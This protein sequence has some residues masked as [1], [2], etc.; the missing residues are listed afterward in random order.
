M[1]NELDLDA[2]QIGM[3]LRAARTAARLTQAAAARAI[4]VDT[5]TISRWE[6]GRPGIRMDNLLRAAAVYGV[7]P[8]SL[9]PG[10]GDIHVPRGTPRAVQEPA[11][12]YG[13]VAP[14]PDDW[15]IRVHRLALE[16]AEAGATE[17][18]IAAVRRWLLDPAVPSQ[19]TGGAPTAAQ[20][21]D[22]AEIEAGAR[23]WLRAR[24]RAVRR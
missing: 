9:M 20:G 11:P 22:L 5:K 2:S 13:G 7:A 24:G 4:G 12:T 18:E 23:A 16:A 10:T 17:E 3:R 21:T 14:W 19:W 15:R 1:P 8:T 6:R